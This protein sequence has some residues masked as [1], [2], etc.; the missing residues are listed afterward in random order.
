MSGSGAPTTNT[1]SPFG[2]YGSVSNRAAAE[3][4]ARFAETL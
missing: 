3:A 1:C 4:M 2:P